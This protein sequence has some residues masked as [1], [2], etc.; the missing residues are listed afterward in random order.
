MTTDRESCPWCGNEYPTVQATGVSAGHG[1]ISWFA[2]EECGCEWGHKRDNSQ[3]PG[4]ECPAHG[5]H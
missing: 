5:T 2:C 4:D 1:E 3:C